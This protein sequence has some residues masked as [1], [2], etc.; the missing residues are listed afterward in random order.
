MQIVI[1]RA[2]RSDYLANPMSIEEYRALVREVKIRILIRFAA[3][4]G[5]GVA[6][7]F[8]LN[9]ANLNEGAALAICLT[10]ALLLEAWLFVRKPLVLNIGAQSIKMPPWLTVLQND[11]APEDLEAEAGDNNLNRELLDKIKKQGRNVLRFE[12]KFLYNR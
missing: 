5:F 12:Q 2:S 9:N 8:L 4:T 7:Y 1:D 11:K 6:F 3:L 10:P